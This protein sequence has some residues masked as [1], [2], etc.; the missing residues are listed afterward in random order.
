MYLGYAVN[1]RP[2]H[3]AFPAPG[4]DKKVAHLEDEFSVKIVSKGCYHFSFMG[5]VEA[6]QK[7][8]RTTSHTELSIDL[9]SATRYDIEK[10]MNAGIDLYGR[11]LR[12]KKVNSLFNLDKRLRE[13]IS[14]CK[15]QDGAE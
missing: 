12:F 4:F 6:I 1:F 8:I 15:I 2:L 5:G 11:D 3:P 14:A 10:K 13:I 9:L 7:K